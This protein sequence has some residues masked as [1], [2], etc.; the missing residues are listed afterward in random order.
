MPNI[1]PGD[2][3]ALERWEDAA[4]IAG[5]GPYPSFWGLRART[6]VW[7]W[8]LPLERPRVAYKLGK[9]S[10]VE[11]P[12]RIVSLFIQP[13]EDRVSVVWVGEWTPAP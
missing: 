11:M 1:E 7:R 5:R 6:P 2:S 8:Q 9:Q 13:D 3:P 4:P 12:A 10:P